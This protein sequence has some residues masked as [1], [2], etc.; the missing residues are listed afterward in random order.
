MDYGTLD[1]SVGG[2]VPGVAQDA[3]G[4]Q[5]GVLWSKFVLATNVD[6]N[7]FCDMDFGRLSE[8][9]ADGIAYIFDSNGNI[10]YISNDE[11][12]NLLPQFSLGQ[13][14]SSRLRRGI[15]SV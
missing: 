9:T 12:T 4:L 6:S 14:R 8:L 10:R 15:S 5:V 2:Q 1:P 7:H 3:V 11:G 13:A